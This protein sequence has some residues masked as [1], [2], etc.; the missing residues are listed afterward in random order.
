MSVITV[1]VIEA[2]ESHDAINAML[3]IKAEMQGV[4]ARLTQA[5]SK[6][7]QYRDIV[8]TTT[9]ISTALKAELL[10]NYQ[11]VVAALNALAGHS[12]FIDGIEVE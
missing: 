12:D 2:K 5:Q 3:T 8:D 1:E 4:K 7:I 11:L 10:A 9:D 6:I